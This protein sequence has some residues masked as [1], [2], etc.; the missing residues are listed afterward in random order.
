MEK[1][2]VELQTKYLEELVMSYFQVV[3]Q[4]RFRN[5]GGNVLLCR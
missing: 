1:M 2:D 5:H 4:L 3:W